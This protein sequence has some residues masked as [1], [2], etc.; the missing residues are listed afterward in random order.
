MTNEKKLALICASMDRIIKIV[1]RMPE[2]VRA[3]L[4]DELNEKFGEQ[5]V[6]L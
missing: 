6:E 4:L 5:N 1:E 2:Y 3:Q